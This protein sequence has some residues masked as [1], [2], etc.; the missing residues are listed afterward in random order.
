MGISSKKSSSVCDHEPPLLRTKPFAA[1]PAELGGG[2]KSTSTPITDAEISLGA[3]TATRRKQRL[4]LSD[5]VAEL[6]P[7]AHGGD[8]SATAVDLSDLDA[9]PYVRNPSRRDEPG[10]LSQTSVPR[11]GVSGNVGGEIGAAIE[12]VLLERPSGQV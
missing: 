4:P 3:A 1:E 2:R 12:A 7:R 10:V 5:V 11:A 9:E 8:L 6:A